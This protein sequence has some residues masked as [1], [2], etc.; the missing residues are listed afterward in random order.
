[1][2]NLSRAANRTKWLMIVNAYEQSE[3]SKEQFCIEKNIK[4]ATLDYWIRKSRTQNEQ[5]SIAMPRFANIISKIQ[6]LDELRLHFRG[7]DVFVPIRTE[8]TVLKNLIEGL[9]Q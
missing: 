1:M 2:S 5:A 4:K 8:V 3:L 6:P 9:A 7:V